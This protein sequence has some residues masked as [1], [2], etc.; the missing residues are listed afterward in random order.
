MNN[1]D[2]EASKSKIEPKNLTTDLP[3]TNETTQSGYDQVPDFGSLNEEQETLKC[4]VLSGNFSNVADIIPSEEQSPKLKADLKNLL[5]SFDKMTKY[6]EN[7]LSKKNEELL[8]VKEDNQVLHKKND[9]LHEVTQT[10]YGENEKLLRY[11]K[12][13]LKHNKELFRHNEQL[14]QTNQELQRK[15]EIAD[16]SEHKKNSKSLVFNNSSPNFKQTGP[17]NTE[18]SQLTK[19]LND[20][21]ILIARYESIIKELDGDIGNL[22]VELANLGEELNHKSTILFRTEAFSARLVADIRAVQR[23]YSK[24]LTKLEIVQF[25]EN[26]KKKINYRGLIEL[27]CFVYDLARL[28]Q[29]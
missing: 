24:K 13:L 7:E 25:N 14:H 2:K 17:N 18:I 11:N 28:V 23:R 27:R 16:A 8:K 26:K 10:F 22:R 9:N 5:A 3:P 29:L 4:P 19:Q 21:N 6:Y 15:N 1:E 12:E 20:K